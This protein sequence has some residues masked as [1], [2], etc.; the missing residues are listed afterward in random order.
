MVDTN[1]EHNGASK[2]G[3]HKSAD[4]K[5]QAK[6]VWSFMYMVINQTGEQ[7]LHGSLK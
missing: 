1:G 4:H 5:N 6:A 7:L 2:V 3:V